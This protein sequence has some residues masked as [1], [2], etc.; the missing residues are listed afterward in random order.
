MDVQITDMLSAHVALSAKYNT[1][2]VEVR[3]MKQAGGVKKTFFTP[4]VLN[5]IYDKAHEVTAILAMIRWG[6]DA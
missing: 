6:T 2:S 5:L 4:S 3:C 1:P